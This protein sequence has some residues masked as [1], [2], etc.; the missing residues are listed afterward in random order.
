MRAAN[1]PRCRGDGGPPV[2][3]AIDH[4]VRRT[5]RR[6]SARSR[7]TR[8]AQPMNDAVEDMLEIEPRHTPADEW[9]GW[10]KHSA[11]YISSNHHLLTRKPMQPG[12]LVA[13]GVGIDCLSAIE[14]AM[15]NRTPAAA[16]PARRPACLRDNRIGMRSCSFG[17]VKSCSS[18][19]LLRSR[20]RHG[21]ACSKRSTRLT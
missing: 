14:S 7:S 13:N 4:E 6:Q 8:V 2:H 1:V 3:Q 20:A 11:S 15:A 21:P 17:T 19:P 18:M 5:P 16:V 10:T 12:K 9:V